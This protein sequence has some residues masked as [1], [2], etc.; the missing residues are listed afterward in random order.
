MHNVRNG[1]GE[2]KQIIDN[3]DSNLQIKQDN[4]N[5]EDELYSQTSYRKPQD[6]NERTLEAEEELKFSQQE[7]V[8]FEN[9]Q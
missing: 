6:E 9:V 1:Y 4:S 8:N 2:F 7:D 3:L 5:L